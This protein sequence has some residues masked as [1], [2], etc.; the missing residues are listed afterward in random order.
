MVS[1]SVTKQDQVTLRGFCAQDLDA[2]HALDVV[3]FE[4]PFRFSKAMVKDSVEASGASVVVAEHKGRI[5]GFAVLQVERLN[6]T[7]VGY[8]VTLD[9]EPALRRH[10]IARRMMLRLEE[11]AMAA[12]CAAMLLH[13]Y[14]GNEGA[15]GFYE[16]LGFSRVDVA[17]SF[18]SSGLDAW[19]YRKQLDQLPG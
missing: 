5:I 18:Y 2:I 6:R 14:V 11:E 15:I 4:E 1:D 3:C 17:R 7:K 8:V 13:V 12:H 16:S 10:G 19:I 9:V